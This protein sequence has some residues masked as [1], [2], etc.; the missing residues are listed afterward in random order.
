M[1]SP[2]PRDAT[3]HLPPL[4]ILDQKLLDQALGYLELE[5]PSEA[6]RVLNAG[7]A[8]V[9]ATFTW[10]WL[11]GEAYRA[12]EEY[13]LA[14]PYLMAAKRVDPSVTDIYLALGWCYK[15]TD[16]L[17][18]AI[19]VLEEAAKVCR[20]LGTQPIALVMYNLACYYSLDSNSDSA[21]SWLTQALTLDHKLVELIAEEADFDNVRYLPEFQEIVARAT[22]SQPPAER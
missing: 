13:A 1:I 21:I 11:L 17:S 14:I 16:Q 2:S 3:G 22:K 7:Q 9:R 4:S 5:L 15:R 12:R 20:V 6:V 18:A 19:A 8:A 10:N